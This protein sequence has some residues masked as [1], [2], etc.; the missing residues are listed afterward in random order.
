MLLMMTA[1]AMPATSDAA[2]AIID[3]DSLFID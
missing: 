3:Y 1:A 2:T